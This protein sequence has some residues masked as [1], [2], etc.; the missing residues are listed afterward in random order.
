M[1]LISPKILAN[2]AGHPLSSGYPSVP[3]ERRALNSREV[4]MPTG[5]FCFIN[6]LNQSTCIAEGLFFF[7][8]EY[9]TEEICSN[10]KENCQGEILHLPYLMA[11]LQITKLKKR[12]NNLKKKKITLSF[13]KKKNTS[14]ESES[15]SRLSKSSGSLEHQYF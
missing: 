11:F 3:Q 4:G 13:K 12:T 5:L 10:S 14:S 7:P 9:C 6:L 8:Q 1:Y 15:S 2:E